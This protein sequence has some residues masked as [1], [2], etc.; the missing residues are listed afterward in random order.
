VGEARQAV[1]QGGKTGLS[2]TGAC[3]VFRRP[4]VRVFVYTRRRQP[5]TPATP[6]AGLRA[7]IQARGL[8]GTSPKKHFQ[9]SGGRLVLQRAAANDLVCLQ[10]L[11]N[12]EKFAEWKKSISEKL[13]G[14]GRE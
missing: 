6:N 11:A 2:H 7:K 5:A 1:P 12:M 10:I 9:V 8:C 4:A 13:D 3:Q 14:I